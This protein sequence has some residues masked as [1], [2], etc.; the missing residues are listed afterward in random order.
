MKKNIFITLITI[1]ILSFVLVQCTKENNQNELTSESVELRSDD[2]I[3]PDCG[4]PLIN[5]PVENIPLPSSYPG[6]C[7]VNGQYLY[8]KCGTSST[9]QFYDFI[10]T[11][12]S[13]P[14]GSDLN[15]WLQSLSD[16][17]RA[18][19]V[20]VIKNYAQSVA[21]LM[22]LQEEANQNNL[23][24]IEKVT[25]FKDNCSQLCEYFDP[26]CLLEKADIGPKE[27]KGGN[28]GETGM[29]ENQLKLR[30][31]VDPCWKYKSIKCGTGCCITNTHYDVVNGVVIEVSSET[32]SH[33]DCSPLPP[34]YHSRWPRFGPCP[35]LGHYIGDCTQNCAN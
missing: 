14:D 27:E 33:G 21:Q 9:F 30:A 5:K 31:T 1:I 20:L 28:R 35:A 11:I 7:L 8:R 18:Q 3:P 6:N 22:I 16:A 19:A 32:N 12:P 10:L 4:G 23:T 2:C 15:N 29:V 17:D 24:K 26:S 34:D 25:T 13:T